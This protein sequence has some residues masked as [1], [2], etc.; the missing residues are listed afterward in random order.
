MLCLP[1][2]CAL[3]QLCASC[4]LGLASPITSGQLCSG[5]YW[6]WSQ[7]TTLCLHKQLKH[8]RQG[9]K[10]K[11]AGWKLFESD[12]AMRCLKLVMTQECLHM[13][14]LCCVSCY[15]QFQDRQLLND[16]GEMQQVLTHPDLVQYLIQKS[17]GLQEYLAFE[18]M[19]QV[20]FGNVP[21]PS[22]S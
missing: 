6:S 22:A 4:L 1:K 20:V 9:L 15:R 18:G 16:H 13:V 19:N 2:V 17:D 7:L 11:V 21:A 3:L 8:G 14:A 12:R 10:I 5:I